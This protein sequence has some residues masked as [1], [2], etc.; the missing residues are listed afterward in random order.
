MAML[1][2]NVVFLQ[3][4]ASNTAA[5][6][7]SLSIDNCCKGATSDTEQ[8]LTGALIATVYRTKVQSCPISPFTTV[9]KTMELNVYGSSARE[10]S[11]L[12]D[13]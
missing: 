10:P 1:K 13:L 4:M 3:S 9:T 5:Q 7:S 8:S 12:L 2:T 11:V 6:S